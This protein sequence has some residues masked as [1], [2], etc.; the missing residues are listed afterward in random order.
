TTPPLDDTGVH[1]RLVGIQ[2]SRGRQRA[3]KRR[4]PGCG[5]SMTR[6]AR[7]SRDGGIVKPRAFAVLRLMI[8]SNFVGCSMGRSAGLA[9]FKILSTKTAVRRQTVVMSGP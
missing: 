9:P 7:S 4:G 6:S 8:T 5:H 3:E 1:R 2:G